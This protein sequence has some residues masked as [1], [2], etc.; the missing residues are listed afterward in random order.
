MLF[1]R[2]IKTYFPGT[3][4]YA[5]C[6]VKA[7]VLLA[8][9]GA[10][11]KSLIKKAAFPPERN[12]RFTV[13]LPVRIRG[14]GMVIHVLVCHSHANVGRKSVYRPCLPVQLRAITIIPN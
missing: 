6:R 10:H 13:F 9:S 7:V 14:E 12:V 3:Y 4:A 1:D 5:K 11:G 2:I 8:Y